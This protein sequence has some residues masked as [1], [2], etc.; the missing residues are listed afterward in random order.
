MKKTFSFN[1]DGE[2]YILKT[3]KPDDEREPFTIASSNMEFDTSKFYEY[4]FGEIDEIGEI[5]IMNLVQADDKVAQR[6]Y[7][8]IDEICQGVVS[9]M[10]DE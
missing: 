8:T 9:K 4:V 3:N 1:F 7:L 5:E 2:N 10:K 6:V